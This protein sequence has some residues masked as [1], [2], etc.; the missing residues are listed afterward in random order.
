LS[1]R[2]A[3][4]RLLPLAALVGCTTARADLPQFDW[5]TVDPGVFHTNFFNWI[6]FDPEDTQVS[7]P[8]ANPPEAT[9]NG[10]TSYVSDRAVYDDN[11]FRLP[12]QSGLAGVG[13]VPSRTDDINTVSGGFDGHW[14]ASRQNFEVYAR[15]D[16]N[17]FAHNTDL[18][19]TSGTARAVA[20]WALGTRLTGQV[21]ASYDRALTDFANDF[22]ASRVVTKDL[23]SSESAFAAVHLDIASH[24]RLHAG[25]IEGRTTH[26]AGDQPAFKGDSARFSAEY[27]ASGG[28]VLQ[29]GYQTT[30]GRSLPPTTKQDT[31]SLQ[32]D[33]PLTS[34]LR[35]HAL[36]GYLRHDYEQTPQYNFSGKVWN[37]SLTWQSTAKTQLLVGGSREVHAYVDAQSTYFVSEVVRAVATWKPTAKLTTEAEVSRENQHFIGPNPVTSSLTLPQHN[38]NRSAQVHLAWAASRPVQILFSYRFLNR[39]SNAPALAFENNLFSASLRARF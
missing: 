23:V 26:S 10:V 37:A 31:W 28:T 27:D 34:V 14:N 13:P 4:T 1:R 9:T 32:L 38:V 8:A 30:K 36:G 16:Y 11:V 29:A 19:N 24:W 2:L 7:W 6:D 18:N 3:R 25:A 15:G 22:T 39:D 20:N 17:R 12:T 5:T 35:L 21:G 33:H